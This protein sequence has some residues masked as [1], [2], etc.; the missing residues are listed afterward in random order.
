L[1]LNG[2]I[3]I[4]ILDTRDGDMYLQEVR[5]TFNAATSTYEFKEKKTLAQIDS[6][7]NL[8]EIT[9]NFN[10]YEV[11][12]TEGESV[13]LVVYVRVDNSNG[14][15][16]WEYFNTK[17]QIDLDDLYEQTE[18]KVLLPFEF[19]D[20]LLEKITGEKGLLRS[21]I[22]GRVDLG[23]GSNGQWAYLANTSGFWTRGFDLGNPIQN[24][25]DVIVEPKQYNISLKDAFDSYNAITPLFWGIETQNGKEYLRIEDYDYTQQDF[26]GIR[27]G[28]SIKDIF[29]YIP[30]QKPERTILDDDLF[31]RLE[32]GY[33]KGG[34]EYEEVIG[35]TSVHGKAEYNT[36]LNEKE[37]AVYS[38]ISKIR[39]DVEGHELARIKQGRFNPD[40]D[41]D[42]DQDLFFRDLIKEGNTFRLRKWEDDFDNE[43]EGGAIYDPK[44]MGNL[45]LTPFRNLLRHKRIIGTGLY[46][47]PYGEVTFI[48]SNCLS[49]F[50]LEG[51]KED[52]A[53]E[54]KDL[55][56]PYISGIM[57]NCEGKVYQE[58]VD[59]LEGFTV[60][61]GNR[62]PNWYGLIEVELNGDL[63]LGRLIKSSINGNGKH[64]IA[65]I[66]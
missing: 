48:S 57:I 16:G 25:S 34:N 47:E 1:T 14:N 44:T 3:G 10:D 54:N 37:E 53:I 21:D 26:I 7:L 35:L 18:S 46:Q 49:S 12:L 17:L 64:E 32:F 43:P 56:D 19:F 4:R 13:A 8:G 38:K 42:Y 65:L 2:N 52:G 62:I 50:T 15:I 51:L 40:E 6:G 45:R 66:P 33:E 60:I 9:Y 61:N 31:T 28:R 27:L 20:R 63:V 5:Y 55:L 22:F 41:T 39:A 29:S 58:M 59:Q 30:A 36:C 23:Y 24:V 11:D